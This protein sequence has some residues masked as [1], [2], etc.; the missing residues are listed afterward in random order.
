MKNEKIIGGQSIVSF[1]DVYEKYKIHDENNVKGF[2]DEFRFL[3]NFHKCDV[4]FEGILYPSSENAYMAAKSVDERVRDKFSKNHTEDGKILSPAEARKLGRHGIELRPDWNEVRYDSMLAIVF[5]KFW[6]NHDIRKLLLDT[7]EKYLE[8]TNH[9]KDEYWG[10]NAWTGAGQNNL[11]K[12]L[13]KV[14]ECLKK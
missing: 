10:A 14:R 4:L 12:I 3:S 8:E 7:G 9:W 5:D 6:R 1:K 2:F 11:G 13:M